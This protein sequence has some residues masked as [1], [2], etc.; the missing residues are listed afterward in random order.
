MR[1][2]RVEVATKAARSRELDGVEMPVENGKLVP[3][4]RVDE[5]ARPRFTATTCRFKIVREYVSC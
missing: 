2:G 3:C 5:H 4:H 1:S